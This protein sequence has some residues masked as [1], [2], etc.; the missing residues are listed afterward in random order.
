MTCPHCAEVSAALDRH[1]VACR[2]CHAGLVRV[3][4]DYDAELMRLRGENAR[5]RSELG[6]LKECSR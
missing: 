1:L 5:L 2:A 3:I 4:T 6:K